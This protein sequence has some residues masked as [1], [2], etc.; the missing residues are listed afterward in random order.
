MVKLWDLGASPV[1]CVR[2]SYYLRGYPD[3]LIASELEEGFNNGFSLHYSGPRVPIESINLKSAFEHSAEVQELLDKEVALGRL[4]GPLPFKPISTLRTSPIGVVPKSDG[5][6]RLIT[7]LSYPPGASVNDFVDPERCSVQYTSFDQAIDMVASLGPGALIA[8]SDIQSA[9]RLLPIRRADFDLLGYKFRGFYYIDKCMP[10]G[11]AISCSTFE[12]FASF[13]EWLV[14]FL[15][16]QSSVEH[17]L[18]DFLF[19]GSKGTDT[20]QILLCTFEEL[21]VDLGVPVAKHKTVGPCTLLS[22]LGLDIDTLNGLVKIPE[23]KLLGLRALLVT[24][25][26]MKKITLK[27]LQSLAGALS[28]VSRAIPSARAFNRRFFD[29][30][31]AARKPHHFIRVSEGM[32]EDIRLWLYFLDNFNGCTLFPDRNWSSNVALHLYTD[33]AGN[34]E[35]GCGGFFQNS[36]F[37]FPWPKHW[38]A[39]DICKDITFLELVPIF[40]AVSIWRQFLRNKKVLFRSDNES[41]VAILNSKTSKS[42]RVM[43]LVRPL[44]LNCMLSNIQTK[45]VHIGGEFNGISDA[46]SRCKW[47]QFR[48]LAPRAEVQPVPIPQHVI[49]RILQVK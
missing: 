44:V 35:L 3:R 23:D 39:S 40:I 48:M 32:R 34:P 22:F 31:S 20:C 36:W 28:F 10:L 17:Y 13:I 4:F 43:S 19:G 37:F 38:A 42:K 7:H 25:L 45:F 5:S 1:R 16:G 41:V 15:S 47:S 14:R 6:W 8:K 18:D 11:A 27:G 2:L 12:T 30:M 9:F 29:A 49:T 21:C 46:I 33:S 24:T 26:K